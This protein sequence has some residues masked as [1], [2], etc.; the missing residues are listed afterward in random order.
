MASFVPSAQAL[1]WTVVAGTQ[2]ETGLIISRSLRI[3]DE[4]AANPVM[5]ASNVSVT[6]NVFDAFDATLSTTAGL[7]ISAI[8][9][10]DGSNNLLSFVFDTP[11]TSAG[12]TICFD[13]VV[14]AYTPLSVGLPSS[15]SGS[16]KQVPGPLPVLGMGAAL[17][18][19][20][21]LK[22]RFAQLRSSHP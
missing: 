5:L 21:K 16:V 15:V 1:P 13:R 11:L 14:S 18:W 6:G 20:R 22:R 17:A 3:D 10:L 9:W 2:T 8:D 4:L 19:S 12:G 7:G